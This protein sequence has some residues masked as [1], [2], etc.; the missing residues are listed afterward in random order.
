MSNIQ[1]F[2]TLETP[3]DLLEKLR[4]DLYRIRQDLKDSCA[5][6]DFFVTAE[7]LLD[8]KYPD[9][10]GKTNKERK[11][12]LR[13]E[14]PLL[15]VT[16]HLANGGKHFKTTDRRH[17]SVSDAGVHKGAFDPAVFDPAAFDTDRLVVELEGDDASAL[18]PEVSVEA[19]AQHVLQYWEANLAAP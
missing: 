2:F 5:A 4:H 14:V 13:K 3:A 17:R 18:G 19:L 7:H 1:G 15:R 16:S 10:G 11:K 6:F 9:T 12:Q 8:W